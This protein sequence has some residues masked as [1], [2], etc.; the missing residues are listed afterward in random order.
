MEYLLGRMEPVR[1]DDVAL[2]VIGH[3]VNVLPNIVYEVT[4]GDKANG[5]DPVDSDAKLGTNGQTV[6]LRASVKD[7]ILIDL[8]RLPIQYHGYSLRPA[9]AR[10]TASAAAAST[11]NA[12]T[13]QRQPLWSPGL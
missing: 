5:L 13:S 2:G 11:G 4:A 8:L 6:A 7:R 12:T 1:S 10:G 3:T 9:A